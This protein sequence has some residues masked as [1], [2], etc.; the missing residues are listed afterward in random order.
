MSSTIAAAELADPALPLEEIVWRWCHEE[1][2]VRI[3]QGDLM[4]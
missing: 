2:Q 1:K 4:S 3:E